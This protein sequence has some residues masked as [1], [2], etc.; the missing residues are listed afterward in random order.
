MKTSTPS[1]YCR[2]HRTRTHA[3]STTIPMSPLLLRVCRTL[4][5]SYII[6]PLHIPSLYPRPH[7]LTYVRSGSRRDN[8]RGTPPGQEPR[9]PHRQLR[10]PGA[11]SVHRLILRRLCP[12]VCLCPP[13]TPSSHPLLSSSHAFS[14]HLIRFN[15]SACM[16]EPHDKLWVKQQCIV[17]LQRLLR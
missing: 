8:V 3:P 2:G 14:C 4:F 12:H 6:T 11:H 7:L 5:S 15:K 10:L 9:P 13:P 1:S 16:Y 17:Y